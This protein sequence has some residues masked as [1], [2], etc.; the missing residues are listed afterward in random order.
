MSDQGE[1]DID[2]LASLVAHELVT[3]LSVIRSA[4]TLLR[5]TSQEQV[6]ADET[7]EIVDTIARNA[8]L[9]Q[10]VVDGL[11]TRDD[12]S[13]ISVELHPTDVVAVAREVV[14]DLARTVLRDHPTTVDGV[15]D[16][17]VPA[18]G[19]R[20]RQ[21][22]VNLLTNAARYSPAGR[23]VRVH[24]EPRED[25]GASVSVR[26]RGGGVA[27]ADAERIFEKWERADDDD[28]SGLGL[29]LHLSRRI[30]RA[31]GGDLVLERSPDGTGAIFVIQLPG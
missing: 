23:E 25:G 17:V 20:V 16:L 9:A 31:H 5:N 1:R 7:R 27:P 29:G 28:P 14:G 10:L 2:E 15:A 26:D 3:P 13:Q 4:A 24:V 19:A 18:D 30:A 6:T 21:M 22:L 12:G 8:E 11:R